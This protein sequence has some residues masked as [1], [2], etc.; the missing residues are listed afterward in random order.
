M[1]VRHLRILG[2]CVVAVLAVAAL[3][4]SSASALPEWGECYVESAH[5]GR[6]DDSNCIVKAPRVNKEFTGGWEWRKGSELAPHPFTSENVGSG[7]AL[8]AEYMVC[9]PGDERIPRSRC[10]EKGETVESE[11]QYAVECESARD[12]GETVG[13][14]AVANV[15]VRFNGCTLLGS[16]PC[17]TGGATEG[18]IL[19]NQL[20]GKLG[21]IDKTSSPRQVGLLLEPAKHGEF[22]RIMC[23][24]GELELTLVVG[25]GNAK[26][27][28]AYTPEKHGGYDGVITPITPINKM[29]SRFTE[30]YTVSP[31]TVNQPVQ[32]QGKHVELLESYITVGTPSSM[33]SKAGLELTDAKT[34]AEP[35]EILTGPKVK[36]PPPPKWW[37]EGKLFTGT[38]A[39][40]EETKVESPL[41]LELRLEGGK[42]HGFTVQCQKV[43]VKNGEIE[44]PSTRSEEAEVYEECRVVGQPGCTAR[45]TAEPV[46]SETIVTEPLSAKLEGPAGDIKLTFK[47]KNGTRI[48]AYFVEGAGCGGGEEGNY[49]ANGDMICDYEGVEKE[50]Q[51]HPL[52][53]TETSSGND[54]TIRGSEARF[55]LTDKVHLASGKLW[56]AY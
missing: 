48:A 23:G 26:E 46:G 14:N 28:A 30:N 53:F 13:K 51:E 45:G 50:S 31:P 19:T 3:A 8:Y 41:E 10:E 55:R 12:S 18:E 20:K 9:V 24:G 7:G 25:Q 47:P 56:S 6:Y 34:V 27:G 52:E 37:L 17:S 16:I 35:L 11:P 1:E 44:G 21:W 39:I 4:S 43:K 32:F 38:E 36:N 15:S 5:K 22:A 33:W 49:E 42:G 40:A 29:T 2:V 54:F